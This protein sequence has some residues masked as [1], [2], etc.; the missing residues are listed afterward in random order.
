MING[1][2]FL[3]LLYSSLF[4]FFVS[5]AWTQVVDKSDAGSNLIEWKDLSDWQAD[6]L[7]RCYVNGQVFSTNN[8]T[9]RV[10][11]LLER[12]AQESSLA[13]PLLQQ[14]QNL[15][16]SFCIDDRKD[17]S[18]SYYD[19]HFNLISIKS[20]LDF[21]TQVVF[22]LHELRHIDL[23]ERGFCPS[24]DYD[25]KE[26]ARLSLATEADAQ[27]VTTL[28]IWRFKSL[29]Y[30]QLWQTLLQLEHYGDIAKAFEDEMLRSQ[31]ELKASKKAFAQWY[32]HEWRPNTYYFVACSSYL[33][34]LDSSK[35]I[36]KYDSLP[37]SFFKQLCLLPD[38]SHYDCL[39]PDPQ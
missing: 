27:A 4:S 17:G 32:E 7:E 25:M 3:R 31:D 23:I 9:L 29:G 11:A 13:L 39:I 16:V 8:N 38:Q 33:D 14:A 2:F 22:L 36:Q 21:N 12:I 5:T 1:N 18:Y 26:M 30:E 15:K 19:H 24:L 28:G 6:F 10:K 20:H 34:Q 37:E 35:H